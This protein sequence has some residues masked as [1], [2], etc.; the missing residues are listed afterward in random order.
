MSAEPFINVDFSG[1]FFGLRQCDVHQGPQTANAFGTM[2]AVW[3]PNR[4]FRAFLTVLSCVG[5]SIM[6]WVSR[7]NA[8][9]FLCWHLNCRNIDRI[10]EGSGSRNA[11][12]EPSCM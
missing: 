11:L 9:R 1:S 7:W 12:Y 3:S 8:Y 4:R 10:W 6:A 2:D 5:R